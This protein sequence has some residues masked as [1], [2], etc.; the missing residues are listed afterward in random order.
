MQLEQVFA[1]LRAWWKSVGESI[2][3]GSLYIFGS[4]IYK[5]GDQFDN[6]I[7]DVDLVT[8]FPTNLRS[9][10][11]RTHWLKSVLQHKANLEREL[12][13]LLQRRD[14]GEPIISF[15]AITQLELES[16]IHKSKV[17]DF[18]QRNSFLP[19]MPA[20][21]DSAPIFGLPRAGTTSLSNDM[22]R[23]VLEY[24][25][26]IR[27]KFFAISAIALRSPLSWTSDVDPV[28]KDLMR[29]AAQA[30]SLQLTVEHATERFDVNVGLG[31]LISYTYSRRAE[32]P[33][34]RQAYDWLV[35]RTGGRGRKE[36]AKELD[37]TLYLFFGEVLYDLAAASVSLTQSQSSQKHIGAEPSELKPQ[38][39]NET[40]TVFLSEV[41]SNGLPSKSQGPAEAHISV[42]L[43]IGPSGLLEGDPIE[44]SA[45]L[46][47]ASFNMKW[48][49]KPYF[50]ID[51]V[52]L[53][54][55]QVTLDATSKETDGV[56]RASRAKA[57]DRKLR[58]E[59]V[60]SD[61]NL[62]LQLLIYHQRILFPNET[63]RTED[64]ALA[65]GSYSLLC[66]DPAAV[67]THF[68]GPLEAYPEILIDQIQIKKIQFGL[69][70]P[71]VDE[72]LSVSKVASPQ[73]WLWLAANNQS[74]R[75]ISQSALAVHFI[76]LLVH[77]IVKSGE[78][79]D[80]AA[81]SSTEELQMICEMRFWK[82]GVH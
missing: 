60:R 30:A 1:H 80:D 76:P 51:L 55:L 52:E 2:D 69:P 78:L 33:L 75:K 79:G 31:E 58:L 40:S 82:V 21:I 12:L 44:I 46:E 59:A 27:N 22:V 77:V 56:S 50:D 19:L 23:Q 4:T 48:R 71:V 35:L 8:V 18:F 70:D 15:V 20:A 63:S 26:G 38:S 34:Y 73:S 66:L 64:L 68:G 24:S 57:L 10:I 9:A 29:N 72:L 45:S 49:L 41:K 74:M 65:I 7:S 28:P 36:K 54:Q 13:V 42:S 11:E 39:S 53:D 62:G 81:E 16:D 32:D 25:Q 6:D 5:D 47:E 17:R 37:P 3:T 14:A 67:A 43:R 61:L